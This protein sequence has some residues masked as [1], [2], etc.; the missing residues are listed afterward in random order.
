MSGVA[1]ILIGGSLVIMF[2]IRGG[3]F[4]R[5]RHFLKKNDIILKEEHGYLYDYV[6][7]VDGDTR[8]VHK[9]ECSISRK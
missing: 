3:M 8:T 5:S 6:K 2:L 9:F 7:W 4:L 1:K